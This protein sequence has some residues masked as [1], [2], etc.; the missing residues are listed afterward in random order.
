MS[1]AMG[2]TR[3]LAYALPA[4]PWPAAW[5]LSQQPEYLRGRHTVSGLYG[6]VGL[7]LE[8]AYLVLASVAAVLI[9][10]SQR[11]RE[12]LLIWLTAAVLNGT[13][14]MAFVRLNSQIHV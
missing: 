5:W 7:E 8:V 1:K 2:A 14:L 9:Y 12:D 4:A 11:R 6:S 13:A 3:R 10:R